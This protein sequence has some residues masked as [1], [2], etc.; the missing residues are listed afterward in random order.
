MK[1]KQDKKKKLTDAANKFHSEV[2]R[3]SDLLHECI[4]D[5]IKGKMDQ[6]KL[7]KVI[8]C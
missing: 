8:E 5:L 7:D 3:G 4:N 6:T 1:L 2:L